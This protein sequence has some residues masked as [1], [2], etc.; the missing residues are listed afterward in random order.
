MIPAVRLYL[1]QNPADFFHT[2]HGG[3]YKDG[4]LSTGIARFFLKQSPAMQPIAI[5]LRHPLIP[6]AVGVSPPSTPKRGG[7]PSNNGVDVMIQTVALLL[8]K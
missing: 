7:G 5:L 6:I 4:L 3:K 8:S 2:E 1:T